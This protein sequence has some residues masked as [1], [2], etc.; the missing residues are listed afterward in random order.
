MAIRSSAVKR[1]RGGQRK[2]YARADATLLVQYKFHPIEDMIK[3]TLKLEG[4]ERINAADKIAR[5]FYP[6]RKAIEVESEIDTDVVIRLGGIC[7]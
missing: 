3:T 6:T 7:D 2:V 4:M 5:Y 1:S